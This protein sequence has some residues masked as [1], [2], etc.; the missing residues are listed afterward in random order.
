ATLFIDQQQSARIQSFTWSP[1]ALPDGRYRFVVSARRIDGEQALVSR[2]IVVDRTLAGLA[3]SPA[4]ISPNGDGHDDTAA[5][6]FT[7]AQPA[8]VTLRILQDGATVALPFTGPLGAGA[9]QLVWDGR[10][11]SGPVA[12][13][14]YQ[15]L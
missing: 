3:V 7:L 11:P 4:A 6:S 1:D 5:F 8:T 10:T 13:G 15:A 9:Q 14:T 2:G 12:D